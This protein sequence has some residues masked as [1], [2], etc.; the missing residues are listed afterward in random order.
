MTSKELFSE[1]KKLIPGGVNSP[2]RAFRGV[3]GE[4]FFARS[5]RGARVETCDSRELVDFVCS[6]G[7]A[8]FGHNHPTIRAAIESALSN[9]TSFGMPCEAELEMARMICGMIPC[10]EMVRM[11]NSGTE[12]T[13]SAI[14]LARGYTGR[15]L[16]VKF[17]GCYHGHAD[18]LLV[19]A[20]SGAL[21][22][23]N[24]DSAGIPADLAKLTIVLPFNDAAAVEECFEKLGE[25][26]AC[27]ILE[28]YP[29]N[30]GLIEP[31]P[32]FLR[33][34]RD[35]CTKSGSL[36]IFDEVIT[37]F[38]AAAGGA[39][40]REGIMPDLCALGKIIGGGLPVGAFCGRR[41]IMELL[42]PLGPVYQAGTLSGNPLAMSA[43]IAA[44]K[45]V[46]ENPPYEMLE[47]KSEFIVSAAQAAAKEKGI[48]L[49]TP[50]VA[51]LFSFFF[52][53]NRVKNCADAMASSAELYKKFFW[54]CLDRG[55]YFAPS[56][57]EIC[58]MSAAHTDGD[59][60]QAAEAIT[61]SIRAL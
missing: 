39:Q 1:S 32:G 27:V 21:T 29:A 58:F 44:L 54:G 7:P 56:A 28:P 6:W 4:P 38:R 24:P 42:A 18:S 3:G 25:K 37:G 5:A 26:I 53:E 41:E 9:G 45:M 15:D 16:I 48:A 33:L 11:T 19:K 2:V 22:F 8:L 35:A 50:K 61:E 17:A 30:V 52:S 49:Q 40:A 51:S 23:G 60:A 34:L 43:G 55:V 47:K 36:L 31:E 12:A 13:M 14:R 20:G 10:A 59:L 57:Y 46:R